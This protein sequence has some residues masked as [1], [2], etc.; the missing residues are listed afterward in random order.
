MRTPGYSDLADLEKQHAIAEN[1]RLAYVGATRARDHLL[2][3]LYQRASNAAKTDEIVAAGIEQ[4][5]AEFAEAPG[6]DELPGAYLAGDAANIPLPAAAAEYAPEIW[7]DTRAAAI[8]RRSRP[9][10]TTA[11]RL[12]REYGADAAAVESKEVSPE[13]EHSGQRG[14]GGTAVGSA[15]H[16][17]LQDVVESMLPDLPLPAAADVDDFLAQWHAAIDRAAQRHSTSAGLSDSGEVANLARQALRNPAVVAGLR[18][19]RLW[20]EIPVAARLGA[21][22]DSVVLEGIIDLLYE[23]DAGGLVILDYK[24][25]N[26]PNDAAMRAKMVNYQWQGAAYAAAIERATG[27]T[28]RA[29]QF[30]FIRY[31]SVRTVDHWRDLIQQMDD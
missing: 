19:P 23:D 3:S 15:I 11:T 7:Q 22:P 26:V 12:A 30:L 5:R 6:L 18:A 9:Q 4:R 8:A 29:V 2:V 20:P 25:D 17:V 27:R 13:A 28:V 14:R 1:V 10:A 31:D 21:A 24:S 16:A